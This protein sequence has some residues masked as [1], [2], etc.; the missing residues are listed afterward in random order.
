MLYN[1]SEG[2]TP[3]ARLLGLT[4]AIVGSTLLLGIFVS[5]VEVVLGWTGAIASTTLLFILPP[6]IFLCLS[7]DSL[8]TNWL[9]VLFLAVGLALG[10][11]GL[12]DNL[13][14]LG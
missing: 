9:N 8:I 2:D 12:L 11:L 6:A 4:C 13:G 10:A 14:A 1:S 7:P 5:R 3:H